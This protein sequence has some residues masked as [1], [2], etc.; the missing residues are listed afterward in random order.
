MAA[1]P[2]LHP[3]W[4]EIL[5]IIYSYDNIP[6]MVWTNGR[7][8]KDKNIL[9]KSGYE[10]FL[11]IFTSQDKTF[12]HGNNLNYR[13]AHDKNVGYRIDYKD[14]NIRFLP[15]LV[16]PIDVFGDP[17]KK[18]YWRKAAKD[19]LI[20]NLCETIIY[21]NKAY[22]C[23][24]A[25]A[26]DHLYFDGAHGWE[27]RP[28]KNPFDKTDEEVTEQAS[29]FCYRCGW[30]C[31]TSYGEGTNYYKQFS[32]SKTLVSQTNFEGAPKKDN[33]QLVGKVN[34]PKPR[35]PLPLL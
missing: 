5:D 34:V 29:D 21:K 10:K 35:F 26:M 1:K 9:P 25:A 23:T 20:W 28:D 13:N 11:H 7:T 15:T 30:C 22:Y 16:A 24:I 18:N 19:C 32:Q 8:F 17:N 4:E 12:N 2:T 6:F 31:H 33:M 14:T 27:I 3:K